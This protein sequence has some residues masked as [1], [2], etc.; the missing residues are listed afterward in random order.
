VSGAVTTA[1]RV[2]R[3]WPCK[4]GVEIG[5]S[6]IPGTQQAESVWF[7][8]C[9]RECEAQIRR[10]QQAADELAE[11]TAEITAEAERR[12]AADSQSEERI[13]ERAAAALA[14]EIAEV[15]ANHCAMR[16]PEW[17]KYFGDVR[18]NEVVAEIEAEKRAEIIEQLK[19]A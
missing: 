18:W 19:G 11:Q 14:E 6:Y 17:E 15:I 13:R 3:R 5:Q 12:I 9:C 7:P 4:C 2:T 8:P 16:R 1:G 10:E